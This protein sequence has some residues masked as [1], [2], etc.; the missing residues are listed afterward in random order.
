MTHFP[1]KVTYDSDGG[2]YELLT[3]GSVDGG[4]V[5]SGVDPNELRRGSCLAA[6]FLAR[7]RFAVL[8]KS[9]QVRTGCLF[10]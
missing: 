2:S 10:L 7:N 5:G 3:F 4:A 8:D 6:V 1:L 9:R